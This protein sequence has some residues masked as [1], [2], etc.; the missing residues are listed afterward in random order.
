MIQTD[1]MIQ[2]TNITD[3]SYKQKKKQIQII[4]TDI[5]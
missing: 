3:I 2:Q 4:Q 1:V 5:Y